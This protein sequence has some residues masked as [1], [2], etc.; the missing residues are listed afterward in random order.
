MNEVLMIVMAAGAV[1]GGF[2]RLRGNKWGFGDK[3][4]TG[5]MLLGSMALSMVGM[6]CIAPVLAQWLGNVIV[7]L[8]RLIGV[9]PAMFGSLLSIDMGGYQLAL[10]LAED[11][12]LGNYAGLVVASIFGCTLVFTIPVGMGMIPKADRPFFAKG[13]MLGLVAMPVGLAAGGLLSGLSVV[14][15]LHQNL[16]IFA[17]AVLLLLGLW[18]IPNKMIKGFILLSEGI[19]FFQ[20]LQHPLLHG[21]PCHA[22]GG[23]AF[24]LFPIEPQQA[25]QEPQVPVEL[26]RVLPCGKRQAKGICFRL[27]EKRGFSPVA[28]LHVP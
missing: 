6:I 28:K 1:L 7:P 4:E 19:P 23:K 26:L 18:K 10:E 17:L 13:I 12:Q 9:D 27:G 16:P 3:F 24:Q 20:V 21:G 22:L 8:Y 11:P 25:V 15:C 14:Q 2:D 5:F